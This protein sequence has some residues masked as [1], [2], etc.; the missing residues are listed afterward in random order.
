[1]GIWNSGIRKTAI[2][3]MGGGQFGFWNREFWG[4]KTKPLS[5][6]CDIE[7]LVKFGFG[8]WNFWGRK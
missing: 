4:R 5:S 7:G 6:T 1:M 3:H 8:N 2:L